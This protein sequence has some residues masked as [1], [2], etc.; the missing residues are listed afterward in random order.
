MKKLLSFLVVLILTLGLFTATA[1]N[2]VIRVAASANPHEIL[3]NYIKDDLKELG[4][5]LE[6][7]WIDGYVLQNPATSAGEYDANFF[8]HRPYLNKYNKSVTEADQLVAVIPVH[9]EPFGIYPG[10]KTS[11]DELVDGDSI[12]VPND[13]SN[14]TRA[15][16]LLQE[17]GLI[18]LPEGTNMDSTV[19]KL[20]V[21]PGSVNL[22]IIE[23]DAERL[24][25]TLQDV[26]FA[27]IN[28]NYAI[29]ADLYPTRD[30]VKLESG[31]SEATINYTNYVVVRAKDADADFVQALKQVLHTDKVRDYLLTNEDFK[32]GV[33]PNFE[34]VPE[35]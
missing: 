20:D 28:G 5:D 21:K 33:V 14:E 4:F 31:E 29:L 6:V 22:E 19:T 13:P 32:G 27:V 11:L 12:A 34:V 10:T 2:K 9:Y 25:A 8:Q 18:T 23:M 7:T 16:L 15:L 26:A 24:P 17:A 35:E 30:A 1:E 3:L